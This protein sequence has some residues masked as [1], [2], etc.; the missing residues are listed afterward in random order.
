[1]TDLPRLVPNARGG[2]EKTTLETDLASFLQA[3]DHRR[4]LEV[5]TD[6]QPTAKAWIDP[7]YAPVVIDLPGTLH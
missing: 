5:D 4:P 2:D 3:D 7:P 1:M 6:S